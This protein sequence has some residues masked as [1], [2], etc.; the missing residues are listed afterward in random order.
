MKTDQ[1]KLLFLEGGEGGTIEESNVFSIE[2]C[3]GNQPKVAVL[4]Q[5]NFWMCFLMLYYSNFLSTASCKRPLCQ[6][7]ERY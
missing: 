3:L 5:I 4:W 1:A 6:K 7:Q 2:P